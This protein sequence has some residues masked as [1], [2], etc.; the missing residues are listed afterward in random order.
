M[1]IKITIRPEDVKRDQRNTDRIIPLSIKVKDGLDRLDVEQLG[2]LLR[3]YENG[4][5]TAEAYAQ[6]IRDEIKRRKVPR[7]NK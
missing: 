4:I 7:G 1:P 5:R 3:G 6:A 2:A